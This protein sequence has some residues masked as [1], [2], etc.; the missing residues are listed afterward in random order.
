MK[1]ALILQKEAW[2][3]EMIIKHISK[4]YCTR[5]LRYGFKPRIVKLLYQP[6]RFGIE[7]RNQR[8]WMDEHTSNNTK[9]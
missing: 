2:I 4:S 1:Y 7:I 5:L 6:N 3:K 9:I 8:Y